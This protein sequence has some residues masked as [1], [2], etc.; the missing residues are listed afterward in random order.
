MDAMQVRFGALQ[1]IRICVLNK[2]LHVVPPTT[3]LI[4][5][6]KYLLNDLSIKIFIWTSKFPQPY[7]ESRPP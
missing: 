2:L 1:V 5:F 3:S 6:W 4:I 7:Y